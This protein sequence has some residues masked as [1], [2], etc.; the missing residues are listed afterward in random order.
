[1]LGASRLLIGA[2]EAENLFNPEDQIDISEMVKCL[3]II[4]KI[5]EIYLQRFPL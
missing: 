2:E 4:R 5:S 1:M 3:D